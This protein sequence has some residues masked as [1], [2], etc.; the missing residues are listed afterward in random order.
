[1]GPR[2]LGYWN[3]HNGGS[4]VSW[5]QSC[6]Y[7]YNVGL[8]RDNGTE[9]GNYYLGVLGLELVENMFYT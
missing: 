7:R 9:H 3:A 2:Q 4:P 5:S 8:Y 6:R 1:M